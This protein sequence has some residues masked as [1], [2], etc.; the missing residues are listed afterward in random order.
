MTTFQWLVSDAP[1]T[2]LW[3]S[4]VQPALWAETGS[5][6]G[7]AYHFTALAAAS[8]P[9]KYWS[10]K[11]NFRFQIVCS[12][13]HKG[14]LRIVYDPDWVEGNEYNTNYSHV[15]DIADKT[16][17]TI[18]IGGG[19]EVSLM[20]HLVPGAD[21]LTEAYHIPRSPINPYA[22]RTRGN[23]TLAVFV[24]NDLTVPSAIA[25]DIEVNVFV[26]AGDDFEVHVPDRTSIRNYVFRPQSGLEVTVADA[27]NTE[28]L[29]A[30]VHT[31]SEQLGPGSQDV[32]TKDRVF[33]G[34]S[35]SSFRTL[36][37]RYNL[38]S[39][40]PTV[41][42]GPRVAELRYC[43]F[44]FL[45][46]NV[47]GAVYPRNGGGSY[48]YANTIMMHWVVAM[49]SGWRGGIRW[50]SVPTTITDKLYTQITR[51][52]S[53]GYNFYTYSDTP[54]PNIVF[55]G[56]SGRI[57]SDESY[58]PNGG[59]I[60]GMVVT[61]SDINQIAEWECPFYSNARFLPGKKENYTEAGDNILETWHA[62]FHFDERD[63]NDHVA[64]YVAAAEDFQCYFFTGL[65][66]IYYETGM[67]TAA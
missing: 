38:H 27:Q 59:G 58:I 64:F 24:V 60:N 47:A 29:G 50:K 23:G 53:G 22:G 32:S 8:L 26:S 20:T 13:F 63:Q 41:T 48:N 57:L 33:T 16:D 11:L 14:R 35:I 65:P 12:A 19:Q 9:F 4:R 1:D 17:F 54:P 37:K 25:S 28:E 18:S 3:E 15:V 2:R 49:H 55:A 6:A 7:K 45:R 31:K 61:N 51:I 30:P 43:M 67:P 62:N 52:I 42:L 21:S 10:G 66:R 40:L 5:G 44:P 36:L 39:A 56:D 46:G 34:E